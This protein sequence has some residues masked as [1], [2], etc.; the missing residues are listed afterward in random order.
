MKRM[1][2]ISRLLLFILL[3]LLILVPSLAH[4]GCAKKQAENQEAETVES[5]EKETTEQQEQDERA[6]L[7]AEAE[8]AIRDFVNNCVN[9]NLEA[10]YQSF[11]PS[12]VQQNKVPYPLTQPDFYSVFGAVSPYYDFDSG[13]SLVLDVGNKKASATLYLHSEG[14]E[15]GP[16]EAHMVMVKIGD[17]WL[18]E[19]FDAIDWSYL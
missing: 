13:K 16:I 12:Y 11:T 8:K 18:V 1:S 17:R 5:E 14:G 7:W 15:P 6:I 2:N 19:S 9:Y 4:T 10:V 3:A